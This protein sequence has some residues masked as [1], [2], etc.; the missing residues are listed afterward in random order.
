[1]IYPH[2]VNTTIKY[3]FDSPDNPNGLYKLI[4]PVHHTHSP[5]GTVDC[6][7]EDDGRVLVPLN[8][9]EY[10]EWAKEVNRNKSMWEDEGCTL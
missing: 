9:E 1:M 10:Q 2:C 6:K 4:F 8:D 3:M 5:E 7:Q